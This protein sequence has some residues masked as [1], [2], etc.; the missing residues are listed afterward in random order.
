MAAALD[1][2]LKWPT[3]KKAIAW[4]LCGLAVILLYNFLGFQPR[5]KQ[6]RGLQDEYERLGKDLRENQAI[7]DN[8]PLVKDEVR[9][10]DAKLALALE[11]LPNGEEIPTLLRTVSD[12]GREAG[13]DFLL[14]KPGAPVPKQFYAE[15]PLE[16]QV[17]G[18]YHDIA[19]FFDRVGRLPRIVTIQDLEL[20]GA[21]AGPASSK[22]SAQTPAG[23]RLVASCKATTFKFLEPGEAAAA[24][25]K[26]KAGAAKKG[27]APR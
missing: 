6:L 14:F 3:R 25:D 7:A 21:K 24:A 9:R 13:L 10:L 16:L 11:K 12:L 19:T 15:V 5:L 26:G 2:Y 1:T 18:R 8:L 4:V 27:G 17:V 22:L 23:M 20:S